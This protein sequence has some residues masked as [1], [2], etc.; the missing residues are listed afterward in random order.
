MA[1]TITGRARWLLRYP[2]HGHMYKTF[3]HQSHDH[4]LYFLINHINLIM[5][6]PRCISHVQQYYDHL[7]QSKSIT[8]ILMEPYSIYIYIIHLSSIIIIYNSFH[9][10]IT[11]NHLFQHQHFNKHSC[12]IYSHLTINYNIHMHT[13]L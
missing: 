3:I 11:S 13:H 4:L 7:I 5:P 9:F 2:I 6:S 12:S 8:T 1:P 10:I